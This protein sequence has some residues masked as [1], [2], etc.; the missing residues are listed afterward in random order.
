M[1]NYA[2]SGDGDGR[3]IHRHDAVPAVVERFGHAEFVHALAQYFYR[4]GQD[5]LIFLLLQQGGVRVGPG[6]AVGI[7]TGGEINA[8]QKGCAALQIQAQLDLALRVA[9]QAVQDVA[10]GIQLRLGLVEREIFREIV[11][12]HRVD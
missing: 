7:T 12:A 8:D 11:R 6:R 2:E 9:L 5:A 4:L 3:G 1:S 10:R